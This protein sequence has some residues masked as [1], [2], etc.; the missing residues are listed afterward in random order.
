MFQTFSVV[1][2]KARRFIKLDKKF[3]LNRKIFQRLAVIL[4]FL[5]FP[6]I[7]LLAKLKLVRQSL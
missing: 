2:L 4:L 1:F 5:L 3:K 7:P 6:T